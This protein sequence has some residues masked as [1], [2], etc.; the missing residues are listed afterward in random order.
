MIEPDEAARLLA[1]FRS[2][3]EHCEV[4]EFPILKGKIEV[5]KYILSGSNK[6]ES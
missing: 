3:L 4:W 6:H 5:M 1:S 2:K